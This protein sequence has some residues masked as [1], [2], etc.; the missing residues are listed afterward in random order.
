MREINGFDNGGVDS[1]PSRQS[2]DT[3][4]HCHEP[5]ELQEIE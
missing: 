5:Q 3:E 2:Q 4:Y 1:N